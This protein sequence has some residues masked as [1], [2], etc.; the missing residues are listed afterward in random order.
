M[1]V[2]LVNKSD[3]RGGAAVVTFRLMEALRDRGVD[4][5]MLVAEKL[6]D[7]PWV[8][9]AA[10]ESKLR[11]GFLAERVKIFMANGLNRA[12]LF[13]ADTASDG[14]DIASHPWVREADAVGLNWINQG[15]LSL[16]GIR[17]IHASGKPI[18]WTMH[19]MWCATGICHHTGDCMRFEHHCGDCFLLGRRRGP[20]D[21]SFRTH[22]AKAALYED[23]SVKFVAV[24]R[25][26]EERCRQSALL[27]RADIRVIPNAFPIRR[28]AAVPPDRPEGKLRIIFGA[29][30]LD[31]P[32][33]G[34]PVLAEATRILAA[35]YPQWEGRV[36]LGTFGS[37]RDPQLFSTLGI[38]HVDLG[39]LSASELP[40]AYGKAT[41]V[42][43][44][45]HFET[46]P[47]TLVE[48]QAYG[49][50]PVAFRRGGQPDIID[51]KR[52]GWLAEYSADQTKAARRLAHGI[53]WALS[54]ASPRMRAEML[55]SVESRFAAES[56][57]DRYIDL[58]RSI[59][60]RP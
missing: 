51:H 60:N 56:V 6:G 57:A 55:A 58:I 48:G 23:V 41:V 2:V 11:R 50:V 17:R 54:H 43:S 4:A 59:V 15:M 20:R 32:I 47:G 26:L 7:S 18:F 1:R 27:R 52:T 42:V 40:E 45:S 29:A 34:F 39:Q 35:E 16:R 14:V 37:I 28:G 44:A 25:W 8:Q 9:L 19:D 36:E 33:K 38:P 12:D 21:L 49:A 10:P 24:S 3:L 13:K 53:D 46:L 22:Q 5:R 31:D 30:R